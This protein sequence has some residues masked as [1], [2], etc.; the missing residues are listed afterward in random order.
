MKTEIIVG[1]EYPADVVVSKQGRYDTVSVRHMRV[2]RTA[3]PGRFYIVDI[4][5]SNGL[6][7]F[8]GGSWISVSRTN[9]SAQT[10]LRLGL[11][12]T[13]LSALCPAAFLQGTPEEQPEQERP[14]ASS[15]TPE[16][17]ESVQNGALPGLQ[18]FSVSRFFSSVFAHHTMSEM[19][20]VFCCGT[21]KTTPPLMSVNTS[22]PTPWVFARLLLI[23][24][25]LYV[26]FTWAAEEFENSKLIPGL[27]FVGTF[28]VPFCVLV[29]FFELNVRRDVSMY[30]AISAV[31]VGG[32][33]SILISMVFSRYSPE[34]ARGLGAMWAGPV[35]ETGKLLTA[36][37]IAG[38]LRNG[39]ILTGLLIGAAVGAGF[40]AFESAGY[41]YEYFVKRTEAMTLVNGYVL[42]GAEAQKAL[43]VLK[44]WLEKFD[45]ERLICVRGLLA[46]FAHVLWTAIMA[47]AYWMVMALHVREGRRNAES[48]SLGLSILAD[49]RFLAFAIVPVLLHMF[50]NSNLFAESI[51][52]AVLSRVGAGIL[53]WTVVLFL[54]QKGLNQIRA[55]QQNQRMLGR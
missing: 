14:L 11:Y 16:P 20:D 1:R 55:E 15:S 33:L 35:E 18:G 37:C 41:A 42:Q 39:R 38:G 36:V 45:P 44:L 34:A 8:N 13:C 53:G 50:N 10:P 46:P 43:Y 4:G 9:V 2:S 19:L 7:V 27:I 54:A 22:W 51:T 25:L 5:S 6:F 31:F 40:A 48:R 30:A 52:Q 23:C 47:G 32:L 12:E 24:L 17:P 28:G 26:G 3:E 49:G 21:E 29:L